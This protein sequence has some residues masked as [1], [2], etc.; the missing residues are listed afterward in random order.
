[1]RDADPSVPLHLLD[2][3][4]ARERGRPVIARRPSSLPPE[5]QAVLA[6][7]R[8]GIAG[9]AYRAPAAGLEARAFLPVIVRDEPVGPAVALAP[10]LRTLL[11]ASV[12]I[13]LLLSLMD[14]AARL[15]AVGIAGVMLG[16]VTSA[17]VARMQYVLEREQ[18]AL[19]ALW[20][21]SDYSCV[22]LARFDSLTARVSGEM[23]WTR[24]PLEALA[25]PPPAHSRP[26]APGWRPMVRR[27]RLRY[28]LE[29][30]DLTRTLLDEHE[31]ERLYVLARLARW[32]RH[33]AR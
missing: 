1:M 15:A 16:S 4:A 3:A 14:T 21:A 30:L 13:G 23:K 5:A 2:R 28:A 9:G 11:P 10:A 26:A 33:R 12:S 24:I 22:M 27:A 20:L 7:T 18:H 29:A 32:R 31:A 6:A 8:G 25:P 17:V 19:A